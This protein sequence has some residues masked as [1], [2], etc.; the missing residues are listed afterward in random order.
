MYVSSNMALGLQLTIFFDSQLVSWSARSFLGCVE[1]EMFP[2]FL[3]RV[4]IASAISMLL[5][6]LL[7]LV[8][9]GR[10][11]SATASWEKSDVSLSASSLGYGE[12]L[13][14]VSLHAMGYTQ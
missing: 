3:F 1:Y 5:L 10:A 11:V 12:T 13:F 6:P 4:G 14:S 8:T 2:N 9:T 7:F